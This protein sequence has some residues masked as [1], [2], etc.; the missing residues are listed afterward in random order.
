LAERWLVWS[1]REFLAGLGIAGGSLVLGRA[2][3]RAAGPLPPVAAL[4]PWIAVAPDGR[5]TIG[6]DKAEMGQGVHSS[7]AALVAE[8]LDV[9]WESVRV[10]TLAL[11]GLDRDVSTGASSSIRTSWQPLREAGAAAR[12]MLVQAA[13][14]AW[15]VEPDA[16]RTDAGAVL[17]PASGR[18][19]G[20]GAL[21]A[22]ASR[23]PVPEAAPLRGSGRL[24]GR[25]LPRLDLPEKVRGAGS[26]GIDVRVEGMVHA[27]PALA[28][29]PGSRLASANRAG[30]LGVAGV[31]DVVEIPGGVAVV[32]EHYWQARKGLEAL[33]PV[34]AGGD[35]SAD[36]DDYSRRLAEALETPG[37]LAGD[38]GDA[39][40]VLAAADRVFEARYEVPFL[41][42]ATMEPMN[43]TARASADACEL[44]AP[45][46]VASNV[47]RDVSRALD[48]DPAKVTVHTTWMG[49]G[50]GRRIEADYAVQAAVAS[51]AVGRP[52]KLLWSREDDVRHDFYR[53]ACAVHLRAALD[54]SGHP[55]AYAH[56]VAGP[57]SGPDG[58]PDWLQ[59]GL[60]WLEKRLESPLFPRAWTPEALWW[61]LPHLARSGVDGIVAG[62]GPPWAYEL[63]AHRLEYSLV[64]IG[65]RIG[66]WRSVGASQNG[67]FFESFVDELAHAAGRDPVAYRLAL[68]RP[69]DRR[70]LERAAGMAGWGRSLPAGH[71][72]GVALFPMYDTRVCQVAEVKVAEGALQV[73]RVWCA[74]DCGRVVNPDTVAAQVEGGILFGLTAALHGEIHFRAGRAVESNFHDVR[75]LS[76]AETP[77]IEVAIVESDRDP[78]GVGEA[79]TPPIAAAVA[80]GLFAATGQRI[81]RLPIQPAVQA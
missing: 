59:Q 53:P 77:D 80:N 50:F 18:R 78:Q 45:T 48:L 22:A 73:L 10:E 20:Y 19:A 67:F 1:R 28:P 33:A 65:V 69:R 7:L 79:G 46:Q 14:S 34:F 21:A 72:L 38:A 42:H 15:G 40:G 76:L 3:A 11:A 49:G 74:L 16:C 39:A 35:T 56:H 52:V 54:A 51:R 12:Q 47:V 31:L 61:R 68:A 60:G 57:W 63:P 36:S 26:F 70:V 25:S 81:R 71:G 9:A 4:G 32:A 17:H 75:L 62:H 37:V 64:P 29:E 23:L 2:P 13:A 24:V 5:V 55:R 41:A 27:A 58:L 44:W 30:A 6:V 43:C 66:W 8:E